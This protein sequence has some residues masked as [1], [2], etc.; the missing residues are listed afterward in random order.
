MEIEQIKKE[1]NKLSIEIRKMRQ[2]IDLLEQQNLEASVELIEIT[3]TENENY[4]SIVN[5][6]LGNY[7]ENTP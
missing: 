6:T 2:K 3:K 1:N 5:F 4:I 7:Q